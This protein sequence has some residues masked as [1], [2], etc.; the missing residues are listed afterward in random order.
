MKEGV[1][2]KALSNERLS[3]IQA[4]D[5]ELAGGAPKVHPLK[6][7]ISNKVNY[8]KQLTILMK[9]NQIV[10]KQKQSTTFTYGRPVSGLASVKNSHARV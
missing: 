7:L 4:S 2:H 1:F 8:N 9:K 5:S 3:T 6:S 10:P